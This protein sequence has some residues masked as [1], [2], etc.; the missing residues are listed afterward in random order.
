MG[1]AH[2]PLAEKTAARV[3]VGHTH[4]PEEREA[5]RVAQMLTA[6]GKRGCSACA[7]GAPCPACGVGAAKLRRSALGPGPASAPAR[8]LRGAGAPLPTSTRAKFERRLG[9][10]LGG[11]RLH[12]GSEAAAATASVGARAFA[13][14]R[15][16]AFGARAP[17]PATAEGERVL[18]HEVAHTVQAGATT[19]LRRATDFSI[20]G[21]SPGAAGDPSTIFFDFGASTMKAS[22]R[23]KVPALAAPPGQALTLFGYSSE[24]GSAASRTT[25]TNNRIASVSSALRANGHT[26]ARTPTP[27]ITRG[28][29]N[30]DYRSMRS[31]AVVPTPTGVGAPPAVS[32]LGSGACTLTMPCGTSFTN[33][34]ALALPQ[35]IA[36]KAQV[37][38]PTAAATT[39]LAALFPGAPLAQIQGN[40]AGLLTEISAL[41][42]NHR[43]HD[44][45]CDA[46]CDRPAYANPSTHMMTLC[47]G[48]VNSAD[49]VENATTLIHEALH[50]VTG[51]TTIDFAYRRSRFIDF[52]PSP[53]RTASCCW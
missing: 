42:A 44:Y 12:Q 6:P 16:I 38:A 30:I 36:A 50:M 48:F 3:K 23:A 35:V 52:I 28:E 53:T 18:A 7:T 9:V 26:A 29:G 46:Q 27:D 43:C 33:A 10:D 39:Q 20:R 34:I 17:S 11:V 31:V 41:T 47:P 49:L 8:M 51:L 5:D 37:D 14:G 1:S 15:D 13:L 4:D 32:P 19:T 22:E 24:E 21:L 45:P 25:L 40:M 2:A